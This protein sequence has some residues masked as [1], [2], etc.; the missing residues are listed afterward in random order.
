MTGPVLPIVHSVLDADALGGCIR[1]R[2]GLDGPFHCELLTRGMNDVYLVR[3][4]G[5]RYAARAWR[6]GFRSIDNVRYEL[7]YLAFLAGC[8][9]PVVRN[10]PLPDGDRFFEVEGLE[11]PRSVAL[12]DWVE[13]GPIATAR[14]PESALRA[15]RI[16][17]RTHL[18][19]PEFVPSV[20]RNVDYIEGIRRDFEYVVSLCHGRAEDL[21]FFARARDAI[22]GGL[23][24]L[25]DSL[26][27][28]PTHGD[29]HAFNAFVDQRGEVRLLDF[30]NC[31]TGTFA[32]ELMSFVWSAEKSELG[33]K[34]INAFL[35]GYDS[36]RR[37]EAREREF[38]P[39]LLASKE[40]RYLCGFA[41]NVNAI[42]HVA[43]RWPGLD[44]FVASVAKHVTAAGLL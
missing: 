36:V 22:A 11:G 35:E 43:F 27:H 7:E 25:G 8:D 29:F 40:Y 28:G 14:N 15:G 4:A 34:F 31:G 6:H 44:W 13:G 33:E 9:L 5:N 17:A 26:P 23:E 21:A 12:F 24:S 41:K 38:F 3:H 2:Y 42:G 16:L 18:A 30:D 20:A 19:G 1:D 39:L 32:Q 37:L 10:R